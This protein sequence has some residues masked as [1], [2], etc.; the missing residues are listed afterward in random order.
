MAS[1]YA[2]IPQVIVLLVLAGVAG[3]QFDTS[4]Q[5]IGG[6][7]AVIAGRLSF[8]SLSLSAPVTWAAAGSDF[9]VYV[10]PLPKISTLSHEILRRL[11]PSVYRIS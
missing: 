1:R 6:T 9:Y 8:F 11:T 3:K 2:W 4:S 5:S 10:S 7:A